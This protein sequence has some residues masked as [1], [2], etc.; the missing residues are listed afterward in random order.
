MTFYAEFKD[1][2][3]HLG[4]E[5]TY[6]PE[7]EGGD[8]GEIFE[9]DFEDVRVFMIDQDY[10]PIEIH[11]TGKNLDRCCEYLLEAWKSR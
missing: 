9:E 1:G 11:P 8:V 6:V 2:P 10:P 4:I 5:G 3:I 7:Q